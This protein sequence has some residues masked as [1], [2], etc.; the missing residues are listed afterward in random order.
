[1]KAHLYG[2]RALQ[3]VT[4]V[5]L[6]LLKMMAFIMWC[7]GWC[8]DRA[9]PKVLQWSSSLKAYAVGRLTK[10]QSGGLKEVPQGRIKDPSKPEAQPGK[11]AP[12]GEA[13]VRIKPLSTVTG[14]HD[15]EKPSEVSDSTPTSPVETD[16][17]IDFEKKE[18][19]SV[20]ENGSM[21]GSAKLD[22][23]VGHGPV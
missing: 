6:N 12:A 5:A 15:A 18:S 7:I 11:E 16:D 22:G 14:S 20:D 19:T 10:K 21:P 23:T 9:A 1:M 4:Y 2:E 3:A 13:K 8:L 17:V